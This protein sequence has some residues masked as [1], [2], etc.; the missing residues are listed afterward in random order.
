MV[1]EKHLMT[2]ADGVALWI[3]HPS[4]PNMGTFVSFRIFVHVRRF[5]PNNY[6]YELILCVQVACAART[7]NYCESKAY[8][9]ALSLY[10]EMA[11]EFQTTLF[12]KQNRSHMT[13]GST[14]LLKALQR[15]TVELVSMNSS[16][17]YVYMNSP[18]LQE[19]VTTCN[20][21]FPK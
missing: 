5:S 13:C 1:S 17:L 14:K 20:Y 15:L 2:S 6:V 16:K 18:G 11:F 12:L 19:N 8:C 3:F 7:F 10:S 21:Q 4:L 9:T